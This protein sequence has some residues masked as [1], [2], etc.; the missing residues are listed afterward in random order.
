VLIKHYQLT[1]KGDVS[2]SILS[3]LDARARV[4]QLYDIMY[5]L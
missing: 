4:T 5:E 2:P 3:T 1:N